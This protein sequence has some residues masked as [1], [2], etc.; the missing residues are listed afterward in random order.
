MPR[1]HFLS[2][3]G[4]QVVLPVTLLTTVAA[5]ESVRDP[6]SIRN[7]IW[8]GYGDYMYPSTDLCNFGPYIWRYH[9][10]W[11]VDVM[12]PNWIHVL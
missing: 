5:I 3:C 10:H 7:D 1:N 8:W 12:V 9:L 11:Y 4:M 2:R 6:D